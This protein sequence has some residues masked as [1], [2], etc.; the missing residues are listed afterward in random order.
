VADTAEADLFRVIETDGMTGWDRYLDNMT[1]S[2]WTGTFTREQA[3]A[4][5][6]WR[7]KNITRR[8]SYK[9]VPVQPYMTDNDEARK[10]HAECH[11]SWRMDACGDVDCREAAIRLVRDAIVGKPA[12]AEVPDA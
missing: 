9:I 12:A 10:R 8:Y 11:G 5:V 3:E 4:A 1:T 2:P 6:D 7:E